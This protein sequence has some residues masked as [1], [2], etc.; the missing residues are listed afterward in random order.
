MNRRKAIRNIFLIGGAG[1]AATGGFTWFRYY[2]KP[3][4]S[5]LD[6][7]RQLL[8]EM[9]EVIIPETDTPGAKSAQ[10]GAF[11]IAVIK[12]CSSRNVQNRFLYGLSDVVGYTKSKYGKTFEQCS[13]SEKGA[14]IAHF[15]QRDKPY[16]GV[17]GKVMNRL[18]GPSFFTTLKKYTVMGYCT[19]MKGATLG[20][21][22]DY[23]PGRYQGCMPLQPG[24]KGWAT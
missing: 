11:V 9:G 7:Y 23:I 22:Y 12:D 18:I 10:T 17:R 13:A 21:A 1:A 8:D 4:L 16:A 6:Q 24:Q 5:D 15:E 3:E 14:V 20:L 2:H 19:S